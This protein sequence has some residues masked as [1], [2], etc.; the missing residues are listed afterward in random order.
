MKLFLHVMPRQFDRSSMVIVVLESQVTF[1]F[2]ATND[3]RLTTNDQQLPYC[4]AS[5]FGALSPIW[6]TLPS[7]SFSGM[8]ESASNSA[9]TCAAMVVMSPVILFIPAVSPL[10]VETMVILSTLASG[11][12]R[13]FTMSGNPLINLSTTAAWLYS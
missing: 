3:Q 1:T 7:N 10:P 9:G 4:F 8:P 13:A 2:L 11:A 6:R 5:G 12:A